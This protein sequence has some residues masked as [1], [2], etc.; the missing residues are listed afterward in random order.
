MDYITLLYI[1]RDGLYY[2]TLYRS[3]WI[4]LHY[5]MKIQMDYIVFI[6]F[7]LASIFDCLRDLIHYLIV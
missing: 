7:Q 1:D 6:E 4:I 5:F 3:R 2:I